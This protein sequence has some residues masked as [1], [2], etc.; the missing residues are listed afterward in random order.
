MEGSAA[1]G[2]KNPRQLDRV[3]TKKPGWPGFDPG[4]IIIKLY[5]TIHNRLAETEDSYV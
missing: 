1:S 3:G 5:N 4:K 2:A